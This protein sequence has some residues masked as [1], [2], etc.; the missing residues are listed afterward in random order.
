MSVTEG[1]YKSFTET[2]LLC[3]VSETYSSVSSMEMY[4]PLTKGLTCALYI[5]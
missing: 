1:S 2:W 3:K 5:F 4:F